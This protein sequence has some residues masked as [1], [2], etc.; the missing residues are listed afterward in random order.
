MIT[1]QLTGN[2]LVAEEEI[3]RLMRQITSQ[4]TEIR[5]LKA[6]HDKLRNDEY[7]RRQ[8]DKDAGDAGVVQQV[9]Q[10]FSR[11]SV[12]TTNSATVIMGPSL[13]RGVSTEMNKRGVDTMGYVYPGANIP[14]LHNSVCRL[15]L[16]YQTKQVVLLYGGNDLETNGPATVVKDYDELINKGKTACA[17][18]YGQC[19]HNTSQT[20]RYD[21]FRQQNRR[22]YNTNSRP[23]FDSRQGASRDVRQLDFRVQNDE[24]RDTDERYNEYQCYSL[25]GQQVHAI[26]KR[27]T[28]KRYFVNLSLSSTGQHYA[29][30]KLQID[31]AAT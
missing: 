15:G 26:N 17:K 12:A 29:L 24:Q 1:A 11:Q 18:S 22:R 7:A 27:E 14:R 20:R 23:S 3:E 21:S 5:T 19:L 4:Q 25:E 31:T 2:L 16:T 13:L 6:E 9:Y 8:K 30:M 28:G 10:L